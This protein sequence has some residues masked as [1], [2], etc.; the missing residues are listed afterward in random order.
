MPQS[1]KYVFHFQWG[2]FRLTIVGKHTILR[3]AA[4]F[5]AIVGLTHA[6]FR[7]SSLF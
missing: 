3:W 1:P 7:I 6:G 5:G 4:L 2:N